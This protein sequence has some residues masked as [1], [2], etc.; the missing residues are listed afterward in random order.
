MIIAMKRAILFCCAV[1]AVCVSCE[2]VDHAVNQFVTVY[3]AITLAEGST[4]VHQVG[5]PW[6][7]PGVKAVLDGNDTAVSLFALYKVRCSLTGFE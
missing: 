4:V 3:P 6:K 1:L 7:D 2:K 5:T